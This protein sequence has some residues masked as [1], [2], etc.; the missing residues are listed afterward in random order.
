MDEYCSKLFHIKPPNGS[1]VNYTVYKWYWR[2]KAIFMVNKNFAALFY[3]IVLSIWQA[4]AVI[5]HVPHIV[6]M[7][8]G[9]GNRL[10]PVCSS[11]T[12]S[13][14][15]STPLLASS[16]LLVLLARFLEASPNKKTLFTT[17]VMINI[18]VRTTTGPPMRMPSTA[19]VRSML[20]VILRRWLQG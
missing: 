19:A 1:L 10:L 18:T 6:A 2:I 8:V 17:D 12:L 16:S 5:G 3:L 4:T 11:D 7:Q 13:T 9:E 15:I 14:T 20:T